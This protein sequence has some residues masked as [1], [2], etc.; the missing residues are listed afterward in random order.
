[1]DFFNGV[2]RAL[3]PA[4]TAYVAGKGWMTEGQAAEIIAAAAA[5][6]AA[7]WSVASKKKKA[8]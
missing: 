5:L 6:G 4:A 7:A 2:L 3:V 1:M 8:Q